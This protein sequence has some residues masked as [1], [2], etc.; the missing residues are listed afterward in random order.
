MGE[1]AGYDCNTYSLK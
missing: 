1:K